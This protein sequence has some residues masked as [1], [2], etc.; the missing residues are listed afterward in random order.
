MS[1]FRAELI[2]VLQMEVQNL[3]HEIQL[4]LQAGSDHSGDALLSAET[5]LA[6]ARS[7]LAGKIK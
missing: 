6:K 3:E 1:R 7:I 4:H 2:S 5:Q